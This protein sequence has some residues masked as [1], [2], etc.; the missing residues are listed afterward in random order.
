VKQI[1]ARAVAESKKCRVSYSGSV[2]RSSAT[3]LGSPGT[4][5]D[6]AKKPLDLLLCDFIN[7]KVAGR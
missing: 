3:C 7:L 2:H 5:T 4:R 1:V 6:G